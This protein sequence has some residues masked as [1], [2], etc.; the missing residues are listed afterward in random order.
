MR[1]VGMMMALA[2]IALCLTM[3]QEVWADGPKS[4]YGSGPTWTWEAPEIDDHP[5]METSGRAA[6]VAYTG[7][8]ADNCSPPPKVEIGG[9]PGSLEPAPPALTRPEPKPYYDDH[10]EGSH[11]VLVGFLVFEHCQCEPGY[12]IRHGQMLLRA[13]PDDFRQVQGIYLDALRE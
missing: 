5:P 2:A 9:W 6:I 4:L 8:D 11:R 3:T 12:T 7:C 13:Q 1:I 10:V